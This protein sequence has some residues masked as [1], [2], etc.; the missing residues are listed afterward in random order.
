MN[1][2]PLGDQVPEAVLSAVQFLR[3]LVMDNDDD[4][5]ITGFAA[6]FGAGGGVGAWGGV[7]GGADMMNGLLERRRIEDIAGE[8]EAISNFF[9]VTDGSQVGRVGLAA[10]ARGA[11]NRALV[12]FE[13]RVNNLKLCAPLLN[14]RRHLPEMSATLL[15]LCAIS[16]EAS[17]GLE[18][19]EAVVE[20][21]S[22]FKISR[23]VQILNGL[24]SA[25]HRN[26]TP[27]VCAML[28][29]LQIAEHVIVSLRMPHVI[30]D[31]FQ[32]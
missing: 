21:A 8:F 4:K 24:K 1:P 30:D 15:N 31:V 7:A 26:I 27:A 23:A 12:P 20:L 16:Q 9:L 18:E 3:D 28:A 13:E 10:E 14:Y 11:G 19:H 17:R 22:D 6:Q 29:R 32:H 25:L 2:N 5:T